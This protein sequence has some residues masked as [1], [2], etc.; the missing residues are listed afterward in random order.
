MNHL[1]T[2]KGLNRL[3]NHTMLVPF[4]VLVA[5]VDILIARQV[6]RAGLR[7]R[8]SVNAGCVQLPFGIELIAVAS[9]D[10]CN[11]G[12]CPFVSSHQRFSPCLFEE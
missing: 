11:G 6:D 5:K 3:S 2:F 1:Q 4:V 10:T 9:F 12:M 8:Q 7:C